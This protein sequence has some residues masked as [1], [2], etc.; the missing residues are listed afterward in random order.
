VRAVTAAPRAAG[1]LL[2]AWLPVAPALAQQVAIDEQHTRVIATVIVNERVVG[3]AIVVVTPTATWVSRDPLARAGVVWPAEAERTTGG[4]TLVDL[5][6]IDAIRSRWAADDV[7]MIEA[8]SQAFAMTTVRLAPAR[9]APATALSAVVANYALTGRGSTLAVSSDVAARWRGMLLQTGLAV[10]PRRR[11]VPGRAWA[12]ALTSVT[13]DDQQRLVRWEAGESIGRGRDG[14]AERV[15]GLS[16]SRVFDIDAGTPWQ[17]PVALAGAVDSPSSA[18]VYV[19]GQLVARTDLPAGAFDLR[20]IPVASGAGDVRVVLRD[21][22]GRQQ[23]LSRSFYRGPS[24]LRR[25]LHQFQH[26]I[27]VAPATSRAPAHL[28]AQVDHRL[29]LSDAITGGVAVSGQ[30]GRWRGGPSMTLQSRAGIVEIGVIG[31]VGDGVRQAGGL[32]AYEY[33]ARAASVRA[34]VRPSHQRPTGGAFAY[35]ASVATGLSVRRG[36][37]LDASWWRVHDPLL[38]RQSRGAIGATLTVSARSH[39]QVMATAAQGASTR[40]HRGIGV[41]WTRLI[42]S[43]AS[44]SVT[45]SADRTG[46]GRA[47]L[48]MQQGTPVGPGAGYSV[49]VTDGGVSREALTAQGSAWRADVQH[50]RIGGFDRWEVG[51]SGAV[52]MTGGALYLSRPIHDAW[53][54]VEVPGQAGVQTFANGQ[55]I[56][57]T[58]RRGRVLAPTLASYAD[59]H[60]SIDEDALPFGPALT[61]GAQT[62]RPALRGGVRARFDAPAT[63]AFTGRLRQTASWAGGAV[64]QLR[65]RGGAV[66]ATSPVGLD[67]TVYFELSAG[68]PLQIDVTQAHGRLSC[69]LPVDPDV[70]PAA[71]VDFGEVRCEETRLVR[72]PA[73]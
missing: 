32:A 1:A 41:T 47:S 51:A 7:L 22:F 68:V 34:T 55:P 4:D 42:G 19:N 31:T 14:G 44:G 33:R 11:D 23:D 27:G 46:T 58:G 57:K 18:E 39:L 2:A 54:L 59:A 43:R 26:A 17:A 60:V 53:A 64:A 29:G 65:G 45:W 66:L 37:S 20:D 10:Q 28:V 12:R 48:A 56:G 9:R 52:V 67:G 71:L 72:G 15:V 50:T 62:V 8:A 5:S 38:G 3:D 73:R 6:R 13:V 70:T 49:Q 24:V 25:G 35:D 21:A 69:L 63:R 30:G 36:L 16:A 61:S 40:R